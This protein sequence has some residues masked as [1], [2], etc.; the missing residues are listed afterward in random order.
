M[1]FIFYEDGDVA[2]ISAEAYTIFDASKKEV[3]REVTHID[4]SNQATSKGDYRH[5][6]EKEIYEQ[7]DAVSNTY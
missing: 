5:Y 4:I 3:A 6:M 7:P 1:I 2:E